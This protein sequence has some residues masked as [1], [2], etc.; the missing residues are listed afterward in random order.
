[1][2]QPQLLQIPLDDKDVVYTPDW[3]ARDM[4]EFFQ[5]SGRILDPC[6]GNGVF[7]NYLPGAEWCEIQD[8][9][10]FFAWNEPVDWLIGNP[11]YRQL[12]RWLKHSM[13]IANHIVYLLP[14]KAVFISGFRIREYAKW[15]KVIHERYYADGGALDWPIHDAIGGVYIQR[16]YEG[17]MYS[18]IYQLPSEST[19]K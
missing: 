18:S 11:P 15:G 19:D 13:S 2:E 14:L 17:P 8:G 1:M 5:P 10:D 3:V 16:G 6:K 4:V 7:L 9:K 12:S